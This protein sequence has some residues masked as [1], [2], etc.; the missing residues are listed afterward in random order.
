MYSNESLSELSL[1][2]LQEVG[3]D[4][5]YSNESLSELSLPEL[6]E[7]GDYFLSCNE[8]LRNVYLPNCPQLEEEM[9]RIVDKN[10]QVITPF[11]IASLDQEIELTTTE[12]GMG[13]RI[14]ERIKSFFSKDSIEK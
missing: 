6:Q 5:L 14:I 4:F 3:N 11:D 12:V 9:Q 1:P 13:R 8:S 2:E 7:V 10:K